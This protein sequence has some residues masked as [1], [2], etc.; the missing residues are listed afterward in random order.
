[1]K[2]PDP[3]LQIPDK[4]ATGNLSG[5]TRVILSVVSAKSVVCI[6]LQYSTLDKLE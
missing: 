1:M 3:I 5:M 4:I 2:H 6:N